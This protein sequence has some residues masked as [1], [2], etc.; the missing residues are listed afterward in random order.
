MAALRL[1]LNGQVFDAEVGGDTVSNRLKQI[2]GE[3]LVVS[4][5]LHVCR[6][7]NEAWLDRPDVQ[8]MDIFYAWNGLDAGRHLRWA[9]TGRSGFQKYL[10]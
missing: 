3:R 1:K 8:V 9:D 4:V 6:H 2:A 10:K 5:H 7:H